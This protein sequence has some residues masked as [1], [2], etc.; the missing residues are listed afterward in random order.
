MELK[1]PALRPAGAPPPRERASEEAAPAPRQ[2]KGTASS[3][4]WT[5]PADSYENHEPPRPKIAA[6][7]DR[8]LDKIAPIRTHERVL[9]EAK[10]SVFGV[11][12][13][14]TFSQLD[15]VRKNTHG[16]EW[17]QVVGQ[18]G[19]SNLELL[20]KRWHLKH[21]HRIELQGPALNTSLTPGELPIGARFIGV[22]LTSDL[23]SAMDHDAVSYTVEVKLTE[24]SVAELA[25]SVGAG[26]A[27]S[28]AEAIASVAGSEVAKVVGDIV[29]GAVPIL[30]ALLAVSS[31]RR[32]IHVLR[33]DSAS[34]EMKAFA[35]GH[36]IGDAVR[37]VFPLAG[38][39]INVGLVGAAALAGWVHHRYTKHA[40]PT[41][42][43]GE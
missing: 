2:T 12:V 9:S 15:L 21:N 36:A 7:M 11:E 13:G 31:A 24:R 40:E 27:A 17:V 3:P 1:S 4:V 35:V 33:D 28:A 30:S 39:L 10:G 38:T 32:A 14:V 37:V 5:D 43:P 19:S 42:P 8:V 25:A 18:D 29:L 34:K 22:G 41:G 23:T 26:T 16:M 6:A 20:L